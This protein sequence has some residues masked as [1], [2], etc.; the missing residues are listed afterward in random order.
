MCI[1]LFK[2]ESYVLEDSSS[3]ASIL[4]IRPGKRQFQGF[5]GEEEEALVLWTSK[6]R[7]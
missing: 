2:K 5:N 1:V 6:M 3:R 7:I 4:V